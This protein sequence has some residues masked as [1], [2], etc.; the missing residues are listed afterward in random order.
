VHLI[1]KTGQNILNHAVLGCDHSAAVGLSAVSMLPIIGSDAQCVCITTA[2]NYG[3]TSEVKG[4][5]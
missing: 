2:C 4:K 5:S 1:V 3:F